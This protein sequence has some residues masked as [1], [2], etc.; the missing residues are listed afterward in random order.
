MGHRLRRLVLPRAP[1]PIV[2]VAWRARA[3]TPPERRKPRLAVPR[4]DA[5]GRVDSD[6]LIDHVRKSVILPRHFVLARELD[7]HRLPDGLRQQR[8]I[9]RN[10]VGAIDPIAAR[11]SCEDDADV[12]DTEAEQHRDPA[13]RRVR[14]LRWRPDRRLGALHVGNG[15]R[16]PDRAVH[17][18]RMQIRGFDDRRRLRLRRG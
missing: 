5:A 15:A 13:A 6:A 7:P 17:L 9:V 18:I 16:R 2:V 1:R 11:A 4:D 10:R 3:G 12:L 8:G 14:R